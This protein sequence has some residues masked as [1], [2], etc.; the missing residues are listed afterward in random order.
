MN[1]FDTAGEQM[2]RLAPKSP[3]FSIKSLKTMKI[4]NFPI[5][6]ARTNI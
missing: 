6:A 3:N 4:C 5:D 1:S 2:S